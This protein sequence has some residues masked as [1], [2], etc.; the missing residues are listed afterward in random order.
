MQL[1]YK[2]DKLLIRCLINMKINYFYDP[3]S[4]IPEVARIEPE[5]IIVPNTGKGYHQC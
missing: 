4:E 1:L 2:Q 3:K 5:K